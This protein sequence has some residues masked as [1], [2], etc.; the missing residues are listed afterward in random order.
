MTQAPAIQFYLGRTMH[1]RLQPFAHRFRY[2]TASVLMD[3]DRLA[4]ASRQ[5]RLFSINRFNLFSFYE[6]DVG[7]RRNEPLRPWAEAALEK[8]GVNLDGGPIRLLCFPRVLGYV[9]NPL[10]VW[11]GH[12]PQG[13][14]RGVIYD[15][16]NTF[17]DAHAYAASAQ[18][19]A[20][21]RQATRKVFHVSP[22]FPDQG[23]Y[24]FRL[25]APDGRYG[26][27]IRYDLDGKTVFA[28]SHVA[29]ARD[30]TSAAALAVFARQPL[31]THAA[32]TGIHWQ[33]LRLWLKGA[34]YHNRPA[35]PPPV[36][37]AAAVEG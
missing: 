7:G 21:E 16:H 15:V 5:S 13:D 32:I 10:S 28:A 23:A 14:L 1:A 2:R 27:S 24:A 12:G 11:F 30:L 3:V 26:L 29:A 20:V 35:P 4:E 18:N 6:R 25:H 9:F 22:F 17:G 33:A 34:R 31:S 36:S 19:T 37:V 8:A